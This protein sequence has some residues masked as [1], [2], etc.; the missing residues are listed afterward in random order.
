MAVSNNKQRG[1]FLTTMIIL[2]ALGVFLE[3]FSLGRIFWSNI[4]TGSELVL[5]ELIA[6]ILISAFGI[7]QI[8]KWRKSGIFIIALTYIIAILE[9]ANPETTVVIIAVCALWIW[10]FLRKNTSFS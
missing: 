10:A 5:I 7:Y 3:I 8:M 9:S 1:A 2:Q 6:E 4:P